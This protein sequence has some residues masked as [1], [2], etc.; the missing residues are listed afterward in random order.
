MRHVDK[1]KNTIKYRI[2]KTKIL[3][4]L[5]MLAVA[6]GAK[7][8]A[9]QTVN[10]NKDVTTHIVFPENIKFV[11]ISTEYLVANQCADNIIRVK[12]RIE[13][14]GKFA[15][16]ISQD[17]GVITIIGERS[18]VQLNLHYVGMAEQATPSYFVQNDET[19]SYVNKEVTMSKADMAKYCYHVYK[20]PR[21]F[22]NITSRKHGIQACV[23]NIYSVG[24]YFFIDFTL[25]NKTK[26]PYEI[27]DMR[28]RI[29][30]K[31]QTKATNVQTIEVIPQF[32]LFA[33]GKFKKE[34]RNVIV[35]DRL[36]FPDEKVLQIEFSE[37][38]ISGR[39]ITLNIEY[40][41]LLNMDGFPANILSNY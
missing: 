31:K 36:T 30:D 12:P 35:L 28:V 11:D 41:D 14:D 27:A 29:T 26:I 4:L 18:M 22:N 39:T 37:E 23:N 13:E 21:K 34:F 15:D 9:L 19:A 38:Q 40:D 6:F 2:M 10:V 16:Y 17:L 25:K 32:K 33:N 8:E 24:D 20:S 3:A 5:V 1:R 7:A